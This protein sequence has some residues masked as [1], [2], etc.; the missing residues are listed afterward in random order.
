LSTFD[1]ANEQLALFRSCHVAGFKGWEG[2]V[3]M[4]VNQPGQD[5]GARCGEYAHAWR[6]LPVMLA[7]DHVQD[8]VPRDGNCRLVEDALN[9]SDHEAVGREDE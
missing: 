7:P 4:G 3:D 1:G 6:R 5:R 2:Q 9:G 8:P